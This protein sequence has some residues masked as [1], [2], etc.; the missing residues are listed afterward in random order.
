M[1]LFT[2]LLYIWITSSKWRSRK[3]TGTK[4][5]RKEREVSQ[6]EAQVCWLLHLVEYTGILRY[7]NASE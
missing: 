4:F 1:I 3:Y 5:G 2:L 6:A 7:R